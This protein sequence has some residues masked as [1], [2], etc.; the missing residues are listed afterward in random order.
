MVKAYRRQTLLVV[1]ALSAFNLFDADYQSPVSADFPM[2]SVP[3]E[4]RA[5]RFKLAWG[6]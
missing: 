2:T 5:L 3:Q 4:G 1:N 6:F